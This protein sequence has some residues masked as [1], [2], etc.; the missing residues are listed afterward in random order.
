M[1][2]HFLFDKFVNSFAISYY[3][4]AVFHVFL[5]FDIQRVPN[6]FTLRNRN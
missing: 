2:Y 5:S 1:L 4:I 3:L 6:C